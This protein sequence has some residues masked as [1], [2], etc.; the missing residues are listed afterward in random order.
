MTEIDEKNEGKSMLLDYSIALVIGIATIFGAWCAYYSALWGGNQASSYVKGIMAMSE[1]STEYLE[2]LNNYN[3]NY[4]SDF[5]DDFYEVQW[6]EAVKNKDYQGADDF[7]VLM[8]EKLQIIYEANNTAED[9]STYDAAILAYNEADSLEYVEIVSQ[10]DSSVVKYDKAKLSIVKG[11]EANGHGDSF[12]FATVLFTIVLFF[13]G[14]AALSEQR[15]MK[16]VYGVAMLVM[17]VYSTYTM[18]II[19]SPFSFVPAL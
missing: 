11:D 3:T 9:D 4:L 12:T 14:M 18:F 19:P 1:S 17:F 5:K 13:G 7:E 15:K 10:I 2:A 8:S 16:L 6:K